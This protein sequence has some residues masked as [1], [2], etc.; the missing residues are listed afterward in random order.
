MK[1]KVTKTAVALTLI[2]LY[3]VTAS[4]LTKNPEQE[5]AAAQA[6]LTRLKSA[7]TEQ[8][9]KSPEEI[10]RQWAVIKAE[11]LSRITNPSVAKRIESHLAR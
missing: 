1:V 5:I 4:A 8:K 7:K 11:A 3:A 2:V 6:E 9:S 10:K